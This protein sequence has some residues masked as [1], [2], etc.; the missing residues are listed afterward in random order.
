MMRRGG[1]GA[2][3]AWVLAGVLIG[4]PALAAEDEGVV[5]DV[6]EILKQ[7]GMIDDQEYE[8]LSLKNASYEKERESEGFI[9]R[10]EWSGDMRLRLENFWYDRDPE[11]NRDDRTRG[12]YRIRIKG[13]VPV[14]EYVKAGFRLASG[15]SNGQDGRD[16]SDP[17]S[18]NRTFG[19]DDDSGN[20][21]IYIDQAYVSLQAPGSWLG[22]ASK[23]SVTGGKMSNPFRW[24]NGKDYMLWDGDITPEGAA[25]KLSYRPT[26][27]WNL[28]ANAGYFI[29]DENSGSR[30]PHVLG[31]QG[32]AAFQASEDVELGGLLG[33]ELRGRA[34]W[35][36]GRLDQR[37]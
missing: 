2:C 17:R 34:Q 8:R 4:A 18:T 19:R 27:L 1:R 3:A 9:S 23:L 28:F 20:D 14:N 12:R 22:E 21:G 35:P 24:K 33:C 5:G 37:R 6:L 13:V 7:R 36:D 16:S 25:A 10:I 11:Q 32:G 26:E 30:D 15:E 31:V 29:M